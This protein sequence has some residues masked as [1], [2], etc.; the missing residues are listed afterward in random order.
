MYNLLYV[1]LI[2]MATINFYCADISNIPLKNR[3]FLKSFIFNLFEREKKSLG[4]LSYIFSSDDYLL[5]LNQEHLKHNFFTDVITFDL[6]NSSSEIAG[7]IY[8]SIER[9]KENAKKHHTTLQKELLRVVF[10]GA[11]HL[12]GYNDKKKS[13]ITI[14]RQKEDEYLRLFEEQFKNSS[15]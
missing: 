5:K 10:H 13:E 1:H 4:S 7:E 2:T 8:I 6:S 12:C 15:T 9:V 11:L 14:M 3:R